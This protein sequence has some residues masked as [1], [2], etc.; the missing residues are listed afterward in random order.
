MSYNTES[1]R[2]RTVSST[3]TSRTRGTSNTYSTTR[4]AVG[5]LSLVK[6]AQKQLLRCWRFV[7]ETVQPGGW[8]LLALLVLGL[9]FGLV[10]GIIEF[11]AAATLALILLLLAVPFLF[12]ARSWQIKMQLLRDRVVAG[13]P[14][15]GTITVRNIG[16]GVSLAARIDVPVGAG[17]V[18]L[19]I[20][21]LRPGA[22]EIAELEIPT[23]S[24]GIINVGPVTAVRS[25]PLRLL[26][27]EARWEGRH[28]LYVHPVTVALPHSSTG[29]LRDL[30]GNASN[31]IVDSDISFHAIREY[32][33]GDS[34][35]H[36]HW[37]ST[38]KT[39]RL[40]VR[41]YEETRRS[42]ILLALAMNEAEYAS[43]E[44]FELAVSVASSIAVRGI[45]DGRSINI[46]VG[47][48]IPE[49]A[50]KSLRSLRKLPT[51]SSRTMLD[52]ASGLDR[53][54]LVIPLP[55]VATLAFEQHPD[56]SLAFL[57]CGSTITARQLQS[58]ALT[59]P[60][61]VAVVALICDPNAEPS[62]RVLGDLTVL[63]IG[64]LDDLRRLLLKGVQ[65]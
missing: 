61:N 2:G 17:L 1:Q 42:K 30:E 57:V 24:R 22:S 38:A 63:S 32:S 26:R 12:G 65:S 52:A 60:S 56:I 6:R 47:A 34:Q 49:F 62:S 40:M 33:P 9:V 18:D 16:K 21:T 59:F 43:A 13:N 28:T 3:E 37:K 64:L 54:E 55:D 48:E 10:F 8:L 7:S 14:A 44:E 39:G 51:V 36:V 23:H 27:R 11:V 20:P 5:G 46:C 50:R 4:L 41:Q 35:R 15:S 25:D 58:I 31:Q 29:F 19:A 45:R 53:N